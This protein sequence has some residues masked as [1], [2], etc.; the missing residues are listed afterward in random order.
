MHIQ[1]SIAYERVEPAVL[2]A[3]ERHMNTKREVVCRNIQ[4]DVQNKYHCKLFTAV[5][6]LMH[7]IASSVC[8]A[9]KKLISECMVMLYVWL[10]GNDE[11]LT[12]N[13]TF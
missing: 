13:L 2:G 12:G 4:N 11:S 3:Q 10:T 8:W 9:E 6:L 1:P 5:C 7:G